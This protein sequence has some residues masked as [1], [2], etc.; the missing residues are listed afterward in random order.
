MQKFQQ[1]LGTGMP[2]MPYRFAP[3][4]FVAV[5]SAFLWAYQ[6][7]AQETGRVGNWQ[8]RTET[9]DGTCMIATTDRVGTSVGIFSSKL[10]KNM[11]AI[12]ITN[13][14][15]VSLDRSKMYYLD[16]QIYGQDYGK[17]KARVSESGRGLM[18]P[19]GEPLIN[20]VFQNGWS[21]ILSYGGRQLS[22]FFADS[23]PAYDLLG[24]CNGKSDPFA[25]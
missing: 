11:L 9:A 1:G 17:V 7:E 15:G 3:L 10:K 24:R 4:T 13:E 22:F 14:N 16:L 18:F 5:L 12:G 6:C 21:V 25:K 20:K 23:K 2:S 19:I 8:Y